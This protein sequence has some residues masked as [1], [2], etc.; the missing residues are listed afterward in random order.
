LNAFSVWRCEAEFR[1]NHYCRSLA[2]ARLH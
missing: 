2:V 1:Y